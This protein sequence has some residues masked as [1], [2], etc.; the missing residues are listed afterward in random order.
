MMPIC[1]VTPEAAYVDFNLAQTQCRRDKTA[2]LPVL[3]FIAMPY[4]GEKFIE[5]LHRIHLR[6][7]FL[8]GTP[9]IRLCKPRIPFWINRSR[10]TVIQDG[11][12]RLSGFRR[13]GLQIAIRV[14]QGAILHNLLEGTLSE[15]NKPIIIYLHDAVGI[16][17]FH[18][19]GKSYFSVV[20]FFFLILILI[21]NNT[22]I[23]A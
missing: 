12:R 13:E 4:A 9:Q 10:S 2:T 23:E 16:E 11:L 5:F 20:K 6:L 18:F 7:I 22:S 1:A 21:N 14:V 17:A 3:N 19:I 15:L 8:Y